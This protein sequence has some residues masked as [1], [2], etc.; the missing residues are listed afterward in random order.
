MIK[1]GPRN[2]SEDFHQAELLSPPLLLT[3]NSHSRW[4]G[5]LFSLFASLANFANMEGVNEEEN[6][7]RMLKGELYYAFMP[8][9]TAKRNRCHHAC[10]RFNQAG[11]GS[12][13]ELV[14]LWKE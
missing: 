6:E 5:L 12:R 14:K 8:K 13:R 4:N 1:A 7:A 11:E 2:Q 3:W 10:H 9:L